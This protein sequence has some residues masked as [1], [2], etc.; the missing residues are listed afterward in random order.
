MAV[1]CHRRV[2]KF[3]LICGAFSHSKLMAPPSILDPESVT[4]EACQGIIA[5]GSFQDETGDVHPV[6]GDHMEIRYKFCL[7]AP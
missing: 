5:S 1:R 7:Q 6:F 2:S 3:D 4:E